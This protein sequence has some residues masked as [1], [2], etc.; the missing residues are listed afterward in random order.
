MPLFKDVL[1]IYGKRPPNL[2][3]FALN[4]FLGVEIS[5]KSSILNSLKFKRLFLKS[6]SA[7]C[8]ATNR[9][10]FKKRWNGNR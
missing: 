7:F 10:I 2:T 3:E 6:S 1:T 8:S 5:N 9:K 4:F